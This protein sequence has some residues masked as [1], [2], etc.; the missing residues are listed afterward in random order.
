VHAGF[1]SAVKW[2]RDLLPNQCAR[3][4]DLALVVTQSAA[5][6]ELEEAQ[7]ERLP[8]LEPPVERLAA[9]LDAVAST[10]LD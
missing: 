5:R 7:P 9:R 3:K 4:G 10:E 1:E 8:V 2:V 6:E